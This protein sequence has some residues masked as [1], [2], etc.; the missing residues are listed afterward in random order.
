[1]CGTRPW[2][3]TFTLWRNRDVELLVIVALCGGRV[4]QHQNS[5]GLRRA[6]VEEKIRPPMRIRVLR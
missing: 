2:K 4:E 1:M 5:G 6:G 3:P